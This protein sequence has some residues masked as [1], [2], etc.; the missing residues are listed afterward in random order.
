MGTKRT[1]IPCYDKAG[2]DEKLFVLR[3][4]DPATPDAIRA[5]AAKASALGHRKEKVREALEYADEIERD[6]AAGHMKRPD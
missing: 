3:G 5:W 4:Q 6:Q 1:G 2:P